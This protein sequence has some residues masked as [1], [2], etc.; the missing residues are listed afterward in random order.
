M[1]KNAEGTGVTP[2]ARTDSMRNVE[3]WHIIRNW[4]LAPVVRHAAERMGWTLAYRSEVERE[5]RRFLYLAVM[6]PDKS[7]GMA[8]P[9]DLLW[10]DHI[11]DTVNYLDFCRQVAGRFLHHVPSNGAETDRAGYMLT[12]ALLD[13]QFGEVNRKVWPDIESAEIQCCS[14]CSHVSDLMAL[15]AA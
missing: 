7:L 13:Q 6:N 8:G 1:N 9:V 5:Y 14:S 2:I 10:H 11:V 4:N 3:L 15:V 12:V